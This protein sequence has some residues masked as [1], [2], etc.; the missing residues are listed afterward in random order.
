MI[1]TYG[2][3]M[4]SR[5]ASPGRRFAGLIRTFGAENECFQPSAGNLALLQRS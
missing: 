3:P 1:R 2:T 4:N 5:A